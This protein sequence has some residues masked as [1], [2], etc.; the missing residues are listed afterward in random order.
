MVNVI[1]GE[2]EVRVARRRLSEDNVRRAFAV[3]TLFLAM[4]LLG[5]LLISFIEDGRFSL[6]DI[7]FETASA[8]A[9][10]GLSSI[11][12]PNLAPASR[13]VLIPMMFLGRVG[14]LTLA[15]ALA[16]RQGRV[17]SASKYPVERIMIG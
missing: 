16:G 15:L 2:S 1:R 4:Q 17:R 12:T 13:V 8:M 3:I 11:G 6:A 14:P 9:T 5:T 10:V 7:W